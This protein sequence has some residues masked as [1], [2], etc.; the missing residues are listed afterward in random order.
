MTAGRSNVE[1]V[2]QHWGTPPKYV[3]LIRDFFGG[4]I[5]LDPC[6]NQY[7]IVNA[8]VEYRLPHSDGLVDPWNASTIFV[9][10][11]YGRDRERGTGI[12]D[13]LRRCREAHFQHNSEVLALV[14]VATNTR[15]WKNFVF[16]AADGVAFL[17]D[18]RLR[19]LENGKD[20]GK[21]APMSC[22]MV[23]WGQR[24]DRFEEM[25]LPFGAVVNL[26]HLH[27][28]LIGRGTQCLALSF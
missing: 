4:T 19:F 5:G 26:K 14:P 13:W 15:H 8:T 6:S 22:A 24:Y 11:P 27:S 7:S 21:G 9:N 12:R 25:F 1:V 17:Y 20:T 18:T 23:Y 16:G 10:P 2:S 3:N 28:K